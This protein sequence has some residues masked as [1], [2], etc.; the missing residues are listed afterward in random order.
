MCSTDYLALNNH[1]LFENLREILPKDIIKTQNILTV[2]D[3][4]LFVWN[5]QDACVLTL[6]LKRSLCCKDTGISHQVSPL[7]V[8]ECVYKTILYVLRFFTKFFSFVFFRHN[9]SLGI[10]YKRRIAVITL[11]VGFF[12][13]SW[14]KMVLYFAFADYN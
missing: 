4:L 14:L 3:G 5:F 9:L 2:N 6:N 11:Y 8:I 13:M 1:K 12:S 10:E 7:C